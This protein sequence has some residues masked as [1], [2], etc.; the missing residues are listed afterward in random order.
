MPDLEVDRGRI[1]VPL[2]KGEKDCTHS[3]HWEEEG[4]ACSVLMKIS[5]YFGFCVEHLGLLSNQSHI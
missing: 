3:S 2:Y 4:L 5:G 1:S